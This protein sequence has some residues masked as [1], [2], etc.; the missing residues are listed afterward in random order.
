VVASV[1]ADDFFP[2]SACG[3]RDPPE[4]IGHIELSSSLPSTFIVMCISGEKEESFL[5]TV[6][7]QPPRRFAGGGLGK[8]LKRIGSSVI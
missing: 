2:R 5:N 7:F 1:S 4:L 3:I 8:L 6:T